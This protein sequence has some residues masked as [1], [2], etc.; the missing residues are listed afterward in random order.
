MSEHITAPAG[1]PPGTGDPGSATSSGEPDKSSGFWDQFRTDSK[2]AEDQF[3]NLQSTTDRK[4]NEQQQ[5]LA[6]MERL[7][8][9]M[10][11]AGGDDALLQHMDLGYRLA[12]NPEILAR[13]QTML[14]NGTATPAADP[15]DADTDDEFLDPVTRQLK[16]TVADQKDEISRLSNQ[17]TSLSGQSQQQQME[18]TLDE[19]FLN[20]RGR[21]LKPEERSEM[22]DSMRKHVGALSASGQELKPR[23][24]N[25][26][27][28][29]WM[30][31]KGILD[32]VSARMQAE[33]QQRRLGRATDGPG[34]SSAAASDPAEFK[35]AEA[36]FQHAKEKW[37]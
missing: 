12:Q 30:D 15:T 35:T 33:E 6:K 19:F 10:N 11:V 27:A 36:A 1:D 24:V 26:L 29:N 22:I 14:T 31:E 2:F 28:L 13:T 4:L 17:M 3:K 5:R 32:E 8:N 37:G 20:G 7:E 34:I 16:Q 18:R 25:V 9:A 23:T 21:V